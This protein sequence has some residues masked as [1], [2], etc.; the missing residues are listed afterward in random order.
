MGN[1]RAVVLRAMWFCFVFL[2]PLIVM[3]AMQY[4]GWVKERP[5]MT[6]RS[7]VRI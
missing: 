4:D 2:L 1:E 3:Y 6:V 7:S 5:R